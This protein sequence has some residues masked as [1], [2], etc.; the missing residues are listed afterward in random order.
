MCELFRP[1]ILIERWFYAST[2]QEMYV[3]DCHVVILNELNLLKCIG[4]RCGRT[5]F[6][7]L[8]P[9]SPWSQLTIQNSNVVKL[10][11]L[12][13]NDKSKQLLYYQAG[14]GTYTTPHSLSPITSKISEVRFAQRSP[15][16]NTDDFFQIADKAVAWNL[17]TH[18]MGMT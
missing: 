18:V 8:F 9:P 4:I 15:D 7:G 2:A 11:Y 17:N 13:I 12:M 14:I 3:S 16:H 1:P 5:W 10:F 6:D